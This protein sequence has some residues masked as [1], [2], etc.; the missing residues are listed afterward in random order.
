MAD[1][2]RLENKLLGA[3]ASETS[4]KSLARPLKPQRTT[5]P[6]NR[7]LNSRLNLAATSH[8]STLPSSHV[9]SGNA[10][11][12]NQLLASPTASHSALLKPKVTKPSINLSGTIAPSQ[13]VLASHSSSHAVPSALRSQVAT[14]SSPVTQS[15]L[16]KPTVRASTTTSAHA[17]TGLPSAGPTVTALDESDLNLMAQLKGHSLATVTIGLNESAVSLEDTASPMADL[18]NRKLALINAVSASLIGSPKLDD[19]ADKTRLNLLRLADVV[20]QQDPEFLLKLALYTRQQL[21]IRITANFLL[22]LAASLHACRPYLRKYFSLSIRL[23]SD[24][25]AVAELSQTFFDGSIRY[26]SLP[27]ALRKAM[28]DKFSEFDEYQLAKYNKDKR[29]KKPGK[30][31]KR[32]KRDK[33]GQGG[34]RDNDDNDAFQRSVSH[35]SEHPEELEKLAFTLKQLIRKLHITQPARLVMGILGKRYPQDVDEYRRSGLNGEWDSQQ[36]GRR[37]RLKVPETWETQVSLHG[38]KASVWESL[39]DHRKLPFMAMLRNLRNMIQSGISQKHHGMVLKKLRDARTVASSRQFPFRFFSAFQV[40]D[41]LLEPS[42]ASSDSTKGNARSSK[43]VD[44]RL[45]SRYKSALDAAVQLATKHNVSAIPGTAIILV[46]VSDCMQANCTAARGL[47][48]PK[49]VQEVALLMGIMASYAAERA[50]IVLYGDNVVPHVLKVEP[51]HILAHVDDLL[52]VVQGM[53][54][55][56]KEAAGDW[57]VDPNFRRPSDND[58]KDVDAC[59]NALQT[60]LARFL[61]T[62]QPSTR[63]TGFGFPTWLLEGVLMDKVDVQNILVFTSTSVLNREADDFLVKYRGMINPDLLYVQVDLGSRASG[64]SE[65]DPTASPNN[66][67][68]AG[69]SDAILRFVAERGEGLGAV[70]YV[71]GIDRSYRLDELMQAKK[72]EAS[73]S[74]VRLSKPV[75]FRPQRQPMDS[76]KPKPAEAQPE[77]AEPAMVPPGLAALPPPAHPSEYRTVRIFISSTFRD[78]Q[79]ERDV[80]TKLVFPELRRRANALKMHVCEIDL[81]WGLTDSQVQSGLAL[82]TCLAQVASSHLFLGLVGTRYGSCVDVFDDS[83]LATHSWLNHIEA[84]KSVTELEMLAGALHEANE[85]TNRSVFA[86]RSDDF[87]QEVPT[88]FLDCVQDSSPSMQARM[89]QLREAIQ[90]SANCSFQYDA[91]YRD[92]RDGMPLAG[93]LGEFAVGV[94]DGLWN[95][96]QEL[97][98]DSAQ[99]EDSLAHGEW[100]DGESEEEGETEIAADD[101]TNPMTAGHHQALQLSAQLVGQHKILKS[102]RT[103]VSSLVEATARYG[104]FATRPLVLLHGGAASGKTLV[105]ARTVVDHANEYGWHSVVCL[106]NHP[107]KTVAQVLQKLVQ[108]LASQFKL[109]TLLPSDGQSLSGQSLVDTVHAALHAAQLQLPAHAHLLIALDS[110]QELTPSKKGSGKTKSGL[111]ALLT[112][113][114]HAPPA[115][116]VFMTAMR[117]G[118]ALAQARRSVEMLNVSLDSNQTKWQLEDIAVP[119][120]NSS[121]RARLVRQLLADHGKQLSEDAFSNQ[122]AML[123]K[124]KDASSP[125]YLRA[126]CEELRLAGRYENLNQILQSLPGTFSALFEGVLDRLQSSLLCNNGALMADFCLALL[127]SVQGMTSTHLLDFLCQERGYNAMDVSQAILQLEPYLSTSVDGAT[128]YML[129]N[130]Q[131]VETLTKRFRFKKG[132]ERAMHN[133]L[134]QY[135]LARCDVAGDDGLADVD[136]RKM[137]G[138]IH[139]LTHAHALSTIIKLVKSVPFWHAVASV[140]LCQAVAEALQTIKQPDAAALAMFLCDYR[141]ELESDPAST[142]QIALNASGHLSIQRLAQRCLKDNDHNLAAPNYT[143]EELLLVQPSYPSSTP[144][145]ETPVATSQ[146]IEVEPSCL[147]HS[148]AGRLVAIGARDG[149][150]HISDAQTLDRVVTLAAHASRVTCMMFIGPDDR[151]DLLDSMQ[152]LTG[153]S[154]GSCILWDLSNKTELSRLRNIN[155]RVTALAMCDTASIIA[156]G[157]WAGDVLTYD[158][159]GNVLKPVCR[160]ADGPI[161]SLSMRDGRLAIGSWDGLVHIWSIQT[162]NVSFVCKGHTSSVQSVQWTSNNVLCSVD[163]DGVLIAWDVPSTLEVSYRALPV[164]KLS[165]ALLNSTAADLEVAGDLMLLSNRTSNSSILHRELGYIEQAIGDSMLGHPR[166]VLVD[167]TDAEVIVGHYSG[168]LSLH[169][170]EDGK[171]TQTCFFDAHDSAVT[172]LTMTGKDVLLSADDHSPCIRVW[173]LSTCRETFEKQQAILPVCE[174]AT[175]ASLT[176]L[177]GGWNHACFATQDNRLVFNSVNGKDSELTCQWSPKQPSIVTAIAMLTKNRFIVS[178]QDGSLEVLDAGHKGSASK[179]QSSDVNRINALD[180]S[181]DRRAMVAGSDDH[182]L[183]VWKLLKKGWEMTGQLVGHEGAVLSTRFNASGSLIG[184][185]SMDGTARIWSSSSYSLLATWNYGLQPVYGVA[186]VGELALVANASNLEVRVPLQPNCLAVVPTGA[187][188]QQPSLCSLSLFGSQSVQTDAEYQ[189]LATSGSERI[190]RF[191]GQAATVTKAESGGVLVA[192]N[193]AATLKTLYGSFSASTGSEESVDVP[194]GGK[195]GCVLADNGTKVVSTALSDHDPI[196][197]GQLDI[198]RWG[199]CPEALETVPLP[200][201]HSCLRATSQELVVLGGYSGELA[202]VSLMTN[203]PNEVL[204]LSRYAHDSPVVDVVATEDLLC[205]VHQDGQVVFLCNENETWVE[206]SHNLISCC[207]LRADWATSLVALGATLVVVGTKSGRL[208]V[209]EHRRGAEIVQLADSVCHSGGVDLIQSQFV[210]SVPRVWS[211]SHSDAYLRTWAWSLETNTLQL[212]SQHRMRQTVHTLLKNGEDDALYVSLESGGVLGVSVTV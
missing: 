34:K 40:V 125:V 112:G 98:A 76:S 141:H 197:F 58:P 87:T 94:L 193:A 116:V 32:D 48:K 100:S 99:E 17:S 107:Y 35:R 90:S 163:L 199:P 176:A 23:P 180:I 204:A 123:L 103:V 122:M 10:L 135:Y 75:S 183:S 155:K 73:R 190:G 47:G 156:V 44:R 42:A 191:V 39:L 1:N 82:S 108:L 149:S 18:D 33:G 81:R 118:P 132:D 144:W 52:K 169:S 195:L 187:S 198:W 93:D 96:M 61:A 178:R 179:L 101:D 36:A 138:L 68:L 113:L 151:T 63:S 54:E 49:T 161:S 210:A 115:G 72:K 164:A 175:S 202:M 170:L 194:R 117:S 211:Y 171:L 104:R 26:G 2:Q 62:I 167:A 79:G 196:S 134:A 143:R 70:A 19:K 120:L 11:S 136:R 177:A 43:P 181:S 91:K 168:A 65:P 89:Q 139:H 121:D 5:Q 21:N 9:L 142:L 85:P 105:L 186:F 130:T 102:I 88:Q 24:W 6:S 106:L 51:G 14:Y 78:M 3:L 205:A 8:S 128:A 7:S 84:G 137:H 160:Q 31:D 50:W 124:K 29:K 57:S 109:H 145:L 77:L 53:H 174:I 127:C 20:V 119:P 158:L 185:S 133:L 55:V 148:K 154:D 129:S 97:A 140:R 182:T 22:A 201:K 12:N 41:E 30:N 46:D 95:A 92:S 146:L 16:L 188:R 126:A 4:S 67:F 207:G 165:E 162:D 147:V 208:V 86:V 37:M 110:L 152:L 28:A 159:Q 60:T 71:E 69:F 66:V 184:S 173:H 38:N 27:T 206:V 157:T 45:L 64:V 189:L 212:Q 13:H 114:Q 172:Y 25:I 203:I 192:M 80:L 15:S 166:A 56:E 111:A 59:G 131:M 74:K 200:F 153:S 150:V 209:L 83:T